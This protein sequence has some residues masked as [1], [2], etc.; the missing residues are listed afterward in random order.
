[1]TES[2][3]A[4]LLE[5]LRPYLVRKTGDAPRGCLAYGQFRT[6][7]IVTRG[8]I[9]ANLDVHVD[10]PVTAIY[11]RKASAPT[12][13]AYDAVAP[14][15]LTRLAL[16]G[17]DVQAVIVWYVSVRLEPQVVAEM[18]APPLTRTRFHL[19]ATLRP[20]NVSLMELPIGSAIPVAHNYLCCGVYQDFVV[21]AITRE[22]ALRVEV[23][24]HSGHLEAIYLKHSTC[25]RF[26]ADVGPDEACI[27]RCQMNWLTTYNPFTLVPTY[28]R[29]AVVYV[30]MGVVYADRRAAG[31]WLISVAGADVVTNYSIVAELVESPIIDRFIPLDA[32]AAAAERCGRF[33]VVMDTDADG[34]LDDGLLQMIDAASPSHARGSSSLAI[35]LALAAAA[36]LALAGSC[37]ATTRR[38]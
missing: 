35:V 25:A 21:P 7:R 10:V 34:G 24:V 5:E 30:P 22:V 4:R 38:R 1:M 14:W 23:T 26:P 3:L 32:E 37:R 2:D 12:I 18:R 29:S 13:A 28:I 17:C 16:S 27:G 33:C 9:D 15:P 8:A 31:D 19:T 20:A 11:A 6:Y 36:S